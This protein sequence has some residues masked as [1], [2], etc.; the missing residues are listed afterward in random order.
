MSHPHHS[1]ARR[2]PLVGLF[3]FLDW[4]PKANRETLI[5]DFL[6]G[7]TGAIVVLPQGVAFATIAGMPPQYGLYAGIVPT[8]VAALFGSSWHLVAGP[9]TTASL[10]LFAS[11][12]AFAEPGSARYVEL[13]LTL[14]AMV[15]LLELSLGVFKLG[16]I[17]NFIS[18]SV[19]VGYTA[20]V[21]I[22][23]IVSQARNFFGV[24][25]PR[26]A[27]FFNVIVNTFVHLPALSWPTTTVAVATLASGI[28]ARRFLP[29]VPF[30]ILAIVVGG[31]VAAAFN[32]WR[33]GSVSTVGALPSQ[34]PPLSAPS[35]DPDTWRMLIPT[36][37]AVA[38]SALNEVVSISRAL[39]IRSEQHLNINQEF[40]GQGLANAIGCFF[41]GYVVSGSFN[42]SALNYEAGGRTPMSALFAAALLAVFLV[43][44]ASLAAYLPHAAM[45]ASLVLVGWGLIDRKSIVRIARTSRTEVGVLLVTILT[46]LFVQI[47][48]GILVGVALSLLIYLYR[49]SNP[50]LRPRV[51]DPTSSGRKFTDPGPGLPE[52]P[53]LRLVRLDGSLFFGAVSSFR[54]A[55]R[56]V[57]ADSPDCKYVAVIMSGVNFVDVAGAEALA[58]EARRMRNSGGG[59][60]FIRVKES[61]R[62][63][64]ERGGY[65]GEIGPENI[66]HSK[67][68]ALRTIYRKLDYDICRRC[69]RR[70]FVECAR[71][72]KQEPLEDDEAEPRDGA[73]A[74]PQSPPQRDG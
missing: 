5:A 52:C 36:A 30:M 45:A 10:I 3:P 34:L 40:I 66:F 54:D 50:R 37:L 35:F 46:A 12:S 4:L 23:I 31:L 17:V 8:I 41:S 72:G 67:T 39:A 22:L 44:A 21:G 62:E 14:A 60:F 70:V 15:G 42:R 2:S 69:G 28:A 63:L 59:L 25:I 57:E 51:P 53:Q 71:M 58:I 24:P 61:V 32:V 7:L 26:S 27:E 55:L 38:I 18:H 29:R 64:L 47:Q 65:A 74:I 43:T 13:A 9:S 73:A 1:P 56:E 19:V 33:P 20:G 6:A 11:L 48:M 68:Q 16:M 49:T